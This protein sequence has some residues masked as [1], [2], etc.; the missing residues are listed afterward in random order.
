MAVDKPPEALG[1][2]LAA[3]DWNRNVSDFLK[4]AKLTEAI[5][6]ANFRLAVWAK[7]F[8]NIDKDNPALSFIRE[9]QVSGHYVAALTALSLYKAAAASMRTMLETALY[10]SYFRTHP[11]E[12]ATLARD[13]N[14]F[15]VKADLLE[16]HKQHTPDFPA[17]QQ[18]LGL[19]VKLNAWY[20][21]VS[22]IT[23]G[24]IPGEWVEHKSLADMKHNK[25]AL[26]IVVTTFCEGEELVHR[27]FLCTV[28][29]VLWDTFSTPAK[30]YLIKG[31]HGDVKA[32]LGLDAA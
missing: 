12:L 25:S 19:V 28:G 5:A 30:K 15:V 31:L 2:A 27:L 9:M 3:V 14:F 23:H 29:R 1:A 4:D 18:K 8:E 6:T 20:G 21:F 10:Y 7:Q 13:S 16:F 22:S 11:S 17:L 26:D 24:Q 32:A